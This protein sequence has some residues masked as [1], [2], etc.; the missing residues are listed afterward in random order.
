MLKYQEFTIE[1]HFIDLMTQEHKEIIIKKL[2]L[3]LF[4]L[5]GNFTEIK[6]RMSNM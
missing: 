6:G 5:Y 3:K 1:R 4:D 2:T